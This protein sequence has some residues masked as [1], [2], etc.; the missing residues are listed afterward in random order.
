MAQIPNAKWADVGGLG[1]VKQEILDTI[2]LPLRYPELF[3]QGIKQRS[4]LLLYGPPGTGKTLMAKA[5]ATEC[6]LN[7][8][9]V[10][11]PELLNM[12]VGESEKNIRQVFE[13]ARSAKPC[14]LFFDELDSLAPLRGRDRDG[15]GVSGPSCSL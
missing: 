15:G 9:S 3:A 11:G 6:S 10:K 5:V 8:L 13:K 1:N 12:Y 7:F 2:D 4:G 14:V